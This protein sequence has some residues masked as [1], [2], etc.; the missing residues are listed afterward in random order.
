MLFKSFSGLR[1]LEWFL[2]NP[3]KKI[4]FNGLLR[5]LKL[6]PLTV[7]EYCEEFLRYE[8]L[9]EERSA[10]LRIFSL[11]NQSYAVKALKTAY[12]LEALRSEKAEKIVDDTVISLALYGSHA[13]GEYD[14][15]S[16]IDLLVIG[17]K[18]QVRH[19]FA[20]KLEQKFGKRLQI[21]TFQLEDWERRK[22]SDPFARSVLKNHV[23]LQ[24][25]QL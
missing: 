23:L 10:N 15:K 9:L 19:E 14:G 4:H 16:D 8:W 11:N 3:D 24:G 22:A 21:T 5:E 13:S 18:E 6:G 17:R 7:K 25:V 12:F 2:K 20:K 1:I